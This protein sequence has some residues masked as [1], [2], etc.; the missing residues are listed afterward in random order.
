MH[1]AT[2]NTH[3]ETKSSVGVYVVAILGVFLIMA[4]LVGVMRHYSNP[5]A[6]DTKRAEERRTALL[7]IQRASYDQFQNYGYV[8]A[9]KGQVRLPVE[10]AMEV[11]V[12]EWKN[13]QAGRSN[14]LSR[15]EIFNKP[16]PKVDFE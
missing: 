8:D 4:A 2:V 9:A 16:P 13:P 3:S 10:R 7:E 14:L 1:G 11:I 15:V 12:Q 5:G 6:V